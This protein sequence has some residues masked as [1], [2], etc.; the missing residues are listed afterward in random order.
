MS[1]SW[2]WSRVR[3][4]VV[5][6]RRAR[7]ARVR[8]HLEILEDRTVLSFFTSPAFAVGATP[9]AEAVGDFNGDGKLDLVV[10]NQGSNT[11]SVL[12]GKGDGTFQAAVNYAD[13]TGPNSVTVGDFN[14]DGN[15]DLA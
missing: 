2:F 5:G 12:L 11:V 7:P 14:R 13:G 9:V 1:F 15:L 10:A 3:K 6:K 8:P 4:P